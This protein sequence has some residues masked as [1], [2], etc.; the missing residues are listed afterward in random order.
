VRSTGTGGTG[1]V[2]ADLVNLKYTS[3]PNKITN[4]GFEAANYYTT[5]GAGWL[6]AGGLVDLVSS[7]VLNGRRAQKLSG[8]IPN[9]YVAFVYQPI[10]VTA[11]ATYSTSANVYVESLSNARVRYQINFFNAQNQLIGSN[12]YRYD[13]VNGSYINIFLNNFTV[14]ANAVYANV[15]IIL[16]P[17]AA[18]GSGTIYIDDVKFN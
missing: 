9:G 10:K 3:T 18:S 6:Q 11:G 15:L 14:P 12:S 1:T 13:V 17:T 16:E 5:R 2:F 8:T 7:P 4:A